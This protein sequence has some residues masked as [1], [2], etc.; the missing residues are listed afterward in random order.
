MT[1]LENN[2]STKSLLDKPFNV[3]W[4][5]FFAMFCM[6]TVGIF[7]INNGYQLG[8]LLII[9][10]VNLFLINKWIDVQREAKKNV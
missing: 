1:E 6:G 3:K 4:L 2:K 10:P 8:V 7:M 5:V 9:I